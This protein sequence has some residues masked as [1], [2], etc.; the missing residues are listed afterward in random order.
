M[1]ATRLHQL[2]ELLG[3]RSR[4]LRV[5][6]ND[7]TDSASQAGARAAAP[8]DNVIGAVDLLAAFTQRCRMLLGRRVNETRD[9]SA[10]KHV[11]YARVRSAGLRGVD[12]SDSISGNFDWRKPVTLSCDP[13]PCDALAEVEAHAPFLY[14]AYYPAGAP[15]DSSMTVARSD[16]CPP[17]NPTA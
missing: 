3:L 4:I 17:P 10:L 7:A 1:D 12:L 9:P 6:A 2:L 5:L 14:R 11:F 8:V 16:Q 13:L 15:C